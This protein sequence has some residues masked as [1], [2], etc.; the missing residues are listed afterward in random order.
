MCRGAF[1]IQLDPNS[2]KPMAPASIEFRY[3]KTYFTDMRQKCVFSMINEIQHD[4]RPALLT[5]KTPTATPSMHVET[6]V[7]IASFAE[8]QLKA[9]AGSSLDP[10]IQA[11]SPFHRSSSLCKWDHSS[12]NFPS[13]L[14][15]H[16]PVVEA[17]IVRS[18]R[19][20]G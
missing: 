10:T 16:D 20:K 3:P 17:S 5:P 2:I 13:N 7:S 9:F 18:S 14:R 19:Q 8:I 11:L 4:I 1:R 12:R 15:R 6:R